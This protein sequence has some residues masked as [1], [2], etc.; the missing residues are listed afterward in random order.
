LPDYC[1][2]KED[3][4]SCYLISKQGYLP[5]NHQCN[6]STRK[7]ALEN[8]ELWRHMQFIWKQHPPNPYTG[9]EWEIRPEFTC[10]NYV[11]RPTK[12]YRIYSSKSLK[13]LAIPQIYFHFFNSVD[14][15]FYELDY[16]NAL[17]TSLN[18]VDVEKSNYGY[19]NRKY[20]KKLF[21]NKIS[22]IIQTFRNSNNEKYLIEFNKRFPDGFYYNNEKI[23]PLELKSMSNESEKT[24]KVLNEENQKTWL[25]L[26]EKVKPHE[27]TYFNFLE[28][29]GKNVVQNVFESLNL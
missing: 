4:Y 26:F 3:C 1:S 29:T 2:N 8:A 21:G 9:D 18:S 7:H 16:S 28:I 24:I 13:T 25:S 27:F 20:L 12:T 22:P 10:K 14:I 17:K 23:D 6:Q 19:W 15:L 11:N 5:L